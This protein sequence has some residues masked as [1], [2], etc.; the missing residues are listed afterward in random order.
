MPS[1]SV[2]HR[3]PFFIGKRECPDLAKLNSPPSWP[4]VTS[5][6]AKPWRN[7]N[8]SRPRPRSPEQNAERLDAGSLGSSM[9]WRGAWPQGSTSRTSET[10]LTRAETSLA[11]VAEPLPDLPDDLVDLVRP[12][13]G[14]FLFQLR[15]PCHHDPVHRPLPSIAF[16][17]DLSDGPFPFLKMHWLFPSPFGIIRSGPPRCQVP[18]PSPRTRSC[19][20]TS[21]TARRRIGYSVVNCRHRANNRG[22]LW[23]DFA[24]GGKLSLFRPSASG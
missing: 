17:S 1:S 19:A 18:A 5:D 4:S 6:D 2:W 8:C 3:S 9:G 20:T 23:T 21:S 12:Q 14:G 10:Y 22:K 24:G 11:G 15:T 13:Q 16:L 7:W